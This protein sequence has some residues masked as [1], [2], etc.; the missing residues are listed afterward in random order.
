MIANP[1]GAT[2]KG[3]Q[4]AAELG[5]F[6]TSTRVIMISL[7]AIVIGLISSGVAWALLK[8]IGLF[9][10]L[11]YYQRFATQLVSPAGNHSRVLGGIGPRWRITH[12][13]P[14]GALRFRP[15]PRPRHSRKPSNPS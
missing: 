8:L 1:N 9:T 5:D 15:H 6:T 4:I 3:Q 7:M 11:F 12:H 2:P 10:N 13:R 14:H